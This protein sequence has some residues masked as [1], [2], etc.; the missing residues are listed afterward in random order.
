MST[1]RNTPGLGN[2]DVVRCFRLGNER[3]I[4]LGYGKTAVLVNVQK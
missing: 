4:S 1:F 2:N 3:C